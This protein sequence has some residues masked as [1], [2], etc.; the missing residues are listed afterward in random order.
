MNIA[1]TTFRRAVFILFDGAR[2]DVFRTLLDG[3]RLPAV[4]EHLVGP[5]CF[6][7]AV[8]AFPTVSG[9]GH[10]P[11]MTGCFPGTL[12]IPGIYWFDRD[13]YG[14]SR[15]GL[16][17][18]R[19]YLGPFKVWKMTRDVAPQTPTLADLWP[20]ALLVFAWYRRGLPRRALL[21]R[22]T[23][24][25]SF[26]RGLWTRD[27]LRCDADAEDALLRAVESPASL[28]F[29]VFP[30][31]D[32]LGHR[33]GPGSDEAQTAYLRLDGTIARLFDRLRR[34]GEADSTL[35]MIGSDHG[36][37]PTHTHFDLDRFVAGRAGRTL[38]YK[39]YATPLR[40]VRA[41]V[42]PSGNGMANVH[43]RGPGWTSG[44]PDLT[45]EPL[46]SL[47]QDLVTEEAVDVVAFREP[48]SG[49]PATIRV[50]GRRGSA[51]L[52]ENAPGE[53]EYA[54]GN[55]DPF[56][57]ENL[58]GRLTF[59]EWLWATRDHEYPDAPVGLATVMRAPRSGD[60]VVTA[61]P[62]FD[63]RSWFE[64]Q[65]PHGT[66]GALHREQALVPVVTNAPLSD[67]PMRTVDV[68]PTLAALT[69]RAPPPGVEGR[70]RALGGSGTPRN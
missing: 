12:N 55:G 15:T 49:T 1:P 27:W 66:H 47:I 4:Q 32:E 7:E 37:S 18:F 25:V 30:A 13:A 67:G 31:P 5:G 22:W 39:R 56:G 50:I 62:G 33:F 64:Y 57:Y 48:R 42:L 40:G 35:V 68:F 29:A 19:S 17:G 26:V 70:S 24:S 23:K 10:L 53:I 58:R 8:A 45:R 60:L 65:E 46:A 20:D 41:V 59:E 63:L 44:R 16:R 14:R 43:F 21:T 11:F 34:R 28:V 38:V 3:G 9:P 2:A 52:R 61:R 69:G 36:Q 51:T 6:R 54:P